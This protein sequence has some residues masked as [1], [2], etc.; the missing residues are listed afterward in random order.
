MRMVGLFRAGAEQAQHIM[1]SPPPCLP[2]PESL[3]RTLPV[4]DEIVGGG[5]AAD[6][7]QA[8]PGRLQRLQ[9]WDH[10]RQASVGGVALRP[11]WARG[12]CRL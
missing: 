11:E 10:C 5:G 9:L 3:V 6:A 4:G 1:L 2:Q 12:A 8:R 7:V